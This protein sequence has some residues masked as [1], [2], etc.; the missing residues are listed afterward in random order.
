MLYVLGMAEKKNVI[1]ENL[2]SDLER[3]A[4]SYMSTLLGMQFK[5]HRDFYTVFGWERFVRA[6]MLTALYNNHGIARAVNNTPV[7]TTWRTY[8]TISSTNTLFN[9][10]LVRLNERVKI[11]KAM[12][13]VDRV[14]GIG[15]FGLIVL[16]VAGQKLSS[17][18]KPFKIKNLRELSVYQESDVEIFY[19]ELL[20]GKDTYTYNINHYK[21][22]TS[23]IHPSRVLHVAENSLD[24]ITGESRLS[25]IYNQLM[26]LWKVSGSSA[27]QFYISASL[28]LNA[29]A[30]DGFK[31]KKADG[32]KLQDSLYELVN[33]MKGFLVTSGFDIKN[34]APPIASPKDSW[35]VL[36]KFV[37]ATTGIPRRLIFGS[38]MGQLA[39]TQDQTTYYERIASR[40]INYV[41]DEIIKKLLDKIMA[42]AT[43][44]A[45]APYTVTWQKLSALSDKEVSEAVEK[46]A[47]S[48][49]KM[50]LSGAAIPKTTLTAIFNKIE[51]LIV[52]G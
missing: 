37:S 22:G 44:F 52:N 23:D 1:V 18:L 35:E 9:T 36:E 40:Q 28:L 14:S 46:Y 21:I 47:I 8:P 27:E 6:N 29:K 43:D 39:S 48:V 33:K 26:D 12:K 51:E 45:T 50:K 3:L 30:M 20:N 17:P 24:G 42:F 10:D 34:I 16:R 11:Y 41:S 32:E 38:E 49:N 4:P 5:N 7:I 13:D 15:T 31:I 19:D 2:I 25:I